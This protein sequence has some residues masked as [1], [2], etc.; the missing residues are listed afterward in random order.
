MHVKLSGYYAL[1]DPGYDYP[2]DAAWPYTEVLADSF[3]TRRLLW[4]SDFSPCL[5]SV[6][7]AQAFGLFVAMPLS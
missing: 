6:T 5:D 3:G 7:F 1:T 4:A 2:H